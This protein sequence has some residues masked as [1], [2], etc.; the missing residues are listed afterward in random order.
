MNRFWSWLLTGR[1]PVDHRDTQ[2]R[3]PPIVDFDGPRPLPRPILP[4]EKQPLPQP[5]KGTIAALILAACAVCVPYLM[6]SEGLRTK[7]YLDPVKIRTVCYG[8][9]NVEMRVYT[10]T[11]CGDMLRR[12][13]ALTYA[14]PILKCIPQLGSPQRVHE[15][16]AMIDSSYNAGPAAVCKSRMAVHF[17]AGQWTAGCKSIEGWY[18]TARDRRTGVRKAY[19]GLVKRRIV[20]SRLCLRPE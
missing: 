18:V 20:M 8:E 7:P 2:Y 5:A 19:P 14:P 17:R 9:T 4:M 10:K 12:Q 1:E 16:A 15:F 6:E 3:A 11:E 13:L